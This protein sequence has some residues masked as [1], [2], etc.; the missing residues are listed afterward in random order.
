[1]KQCPSLRV[2]LLLIFFCF[3]IRAQLVREANTTLKFPA[4]ISSGSGEYEL[5]EMLPGITFDKPVCV[6]TPP[7]ETNR[8]FVVERV[9]RIIVIND[10]NN[11]QKSVFLDITSKVHAADWST[12]RRTEGLSSIAFHP[13]FASNH[14]FF[15]TYNTVTT[16]SQGDGHHNRVA[17]YRASEDNRQGI[18]TSEIALI[19]QFDEGDGH[20]I[21]DLHFGPDGYLYIATGD[22]GD[23]GTGDDFQNAQKINKDFFSAIMRI[24]V[25]KKAE[26][27]APNAHPAANTSAYKI[28]ADNPYIGATSFNG[29][30]VDPTKVRTEFFAVGLRNPWRFS[31]DPATG[32]IYE[33]D[34]GQ[35]RR[36][37]INVI[38]KGGNYG[39]SYKEG[40]AP[41]VYG[42]PGGFTSIDPIWEFGPES[43][44]MT[45]FIRFSVTGGVV[46]RGSSPGLDGHYFFADYMLGDIWSMNIDN[47][48]APTKRF[49]EQGIASFGYDPRNGDVILVN[50]DQGR[51]KKVKYTTTGSNLPNN[52]SDT[53]IFTNVAGLVPNAGIYGYDVNVPLWSDGAA[54]RRWFS[55]PDLSKKMNFSAETNWSF[56]QRSVWIKHFEIES[57]AGNPASTI[58]LETRVLYKTD[59]S[60]YG[61]TYRWQDDGGAA[62]LVGE[63]G[64]TRTY[65]VNGQTRTW[66]F[67]SRSECL[68]CHTDAAGR[69]LGFNTAQLNRDYGYGG[70]P[71]NQLAA[72]SS[73]HFFTDDSLGI[74]N[75]L[76]KLAPLDD[77]SAS[78]THRAKSYLAANC[79]YCHQPGTSVHAA[80]D[81][82][83]STSLSDANIVL[84]GVINP[85]DTTNKVV[86]PGDISKSAII[87][88]MMSTNNDRMPPLGVHVV[89]QQAID[90]LKQWV[91]S[92][93]G[94]ETFD[95]W[96]DRLLV[97]LAKG[98]NDDAD[99]DGITN[100]SE[101]LAGTDPKSVSSPLT[102]SRS[103]AQQI[104]I[105]YQQPANRGFL[106]ETADPVPS[107]VWTLLNQPENR[108]TFPAEMTDRTFTDTLD[109]TKEVKGYR[110]K[111]FE[112]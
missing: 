1:M 79:S 72:L 108:I 24:D 56:P 76:R 11:P 53:G 22:E 102:I 110:I 14:R 91:T 7:G 78:L 65:V 80:W 8:L 17:E 21:N 81:G 5:A 71:M 59:T 44:G 82:R 104:T 28:P 34:V 18:A 38:V 87:S 42:P 111:I 90:L 83:W 2:F 86:M 19:T 41:G 64:D 62:F 68:T 74:T 16:T 45:N 49:S 52:L 32:K 75:T 39:W 33:G 46:Y 106:V 85:S 26:N 47:G 61:I 112:P 50:H 97:D 6:A 98:R 27:R 92:L 30:A 15:V 60:V 103:G 20:N 58:R 48:S 96:A 10:L 4:T 67:P 54:K 66:K 73:A 43:P 100:F 95:A 51:I 9:G 40:T 88:R 29:L 77:A 23:G 70:Q 13:N 31:F 93:D 101:Y 69:I 35:H 99:G 107:S 57:V 3:S 84:G 55:I 63:D 12:S 89:D 109:F 94:Y 105:S 37:E 25:D 36:E